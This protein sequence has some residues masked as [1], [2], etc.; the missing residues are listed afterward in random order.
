MALK[1]STIK[2]DLAAITI[3]LLSVE[4]ET[5]PPSPSPQPLESGKEEPWSI[6]TLGPGRVSQ[7]TQHS[8]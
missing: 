8:Q 7:T 3:S 6:P 1:M 5:V 2:S 4:V